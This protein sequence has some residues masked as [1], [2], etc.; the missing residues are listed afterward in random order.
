MLTALRFCSH[1]KVDLHVSPKPVQDANPGPLPACRFSFIDKSGKTIVT[2]FQNAKEFSEGLAA[3]RTSRLW[4]F[5]RKDGTVAVP[6]QF[7][8]AQSFQE[9]LAAVQLKGQWGFINTTGK[10]V[11]APQFLNT[12]GFS[13]GIGFS[14]GPSLLPRPSF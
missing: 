11:I 7:G 12:E 4:V 6:A 3:V 8:N 10:M 13:E 14:D 5:I 1:P 9:G 2:G